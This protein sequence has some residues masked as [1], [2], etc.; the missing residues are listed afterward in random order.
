MTDTKPSAALLRT[1]AAALVAAAAA[2]SCSSDRP[3]EIVPVSAGQTSTTSTDTAVDP[4]APTGQEPAPT[5]ATERS[6]TGAEATTTG[7]QATVIAVEQ[8]ASVAEPAPST[9]TASAA[10][11]SWDYSPLADHLSLDAVT[12]ARMQV[13]NPAVIRIP[14]LGVEASLIPLGLQEDGSIE[15]PEDPEQAG[16]WLG[17]P[18]PG[19]TGPAVILGHVDSQEEGSGVFFDLRY[20]GAGDEI[21]IDRVD[22]STVSYVVDFLESHDKDEFP[23]DAVYGPTEQPTLRLVTCGGDFDFD[24]RTYEENVIVFASLA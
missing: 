20:M 1:A 16:W 19:E 21:H 12:D 7:S 17:G 8:S 18:E 11:P 6:T 24:V 9:N 13:P 5:V 2:A 23:T 3:A 4:P 22:G 15:I 10:A 14:R